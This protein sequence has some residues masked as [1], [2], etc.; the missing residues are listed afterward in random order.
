MNSQLVD[1]IE[2]LSTPK[3]QQ[4]DV[5]QIYSSLFNH[6]TWSLMAVNSFS[7]LTKLIQFI[8]EFPIQGK[9][10]P[11]TTICMTIEDEASEVVT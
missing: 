8:D 7:I 5:Y 6:I 3:Q 11:D 2:E 9:R 4:T 10:I 1:Y